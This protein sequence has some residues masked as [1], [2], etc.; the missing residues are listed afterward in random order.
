MYLSQQKVIHN[1]TLTTSI[2]PC[3]R[4]IQKALQEAP[5]IKYL[6]HLESNCIHQFSLSS[7]DRRTILMLSITVKIIAITPYQNISKHQNQ[8]KSQAQFQKQANHGKP[9]IEDIEGTFDSSR[10]CAQIWLSKASSTAM[11]LALPHRLRASS[12]RL[13]SPA[14]SWWKQRAATASGSVTAYGQT[15][16]KPSITAEDSGTSFSDPQNVDAKWCKL[17][18]AVSKPDSYHE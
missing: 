17:Q 14:L 12:A 9:A 13:R 4:P 16:G 2:L 11:T 18:A 10:Q 6:N 15:M 3:F 7:T 1:K 8:W 5:K